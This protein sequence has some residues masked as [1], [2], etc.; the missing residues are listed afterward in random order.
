MDEKSWVIAELPAR[1]QKEIEFSRVYAEQFR[2]GASNH[3][4]M[5]TIAILAE[6]LA[7]ATFPDG[8]VGVSIIKAT[9]ENYG[10]RAES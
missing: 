8:N 9:L 4:A 5:V 6:L 3:H 7:V 1:M 2:H 10:V